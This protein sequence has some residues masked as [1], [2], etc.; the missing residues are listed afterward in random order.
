MIGTSIMQPASFKE[1][2]LM[3]KYLKKIR[4]G[5][6]VLIISYFFPSQIFGQYN[7]PVRYRGEFSFIVINDS[8]NIEQLEI[9]IPGILE[10]ENQKD[11]I[12]HRVTPD[13]VSN[14]IDKERK[15]GILYWK[16]GGLPLK[17]N[18]L[19]VRVEFS[20]TSYEVNYKIDPGRVVE[21]DIKSE[22]YRQFTKAEPYIESDR[23]KIREL[24]EEIVRNEKNHYRKARKI[25]DW[26]IDN[27]D[28]RLLPGLEGAAYALEKKHGECGEYSALFTALCRAAGIPARPVIG[29]MANP[30]NEPH[31][32]AEFYLENIGWIPVDATYADG[33]KNKDSWFGRLDNGR[34][35]LSKGFNV[36]LIPEIEI[37]SLPIFQIGAWWYKGD[38]AGARNTVSLNMKAESVIS[39]NKVKEY[40]NDKYG[41]EL[42]LPEEWEITNIGNIGSYNVYVEMWNRTRESR[43]CLYGREWREGEIKISPEEITEKDLNFFSKNLQGFKLFDKGIEKFRYIEGYGF[44]S[45]M[46]SY[47][48]GEYFSKYVYFT[49]DKLIYWLVFHSTEKNYPVD[50]KHFIK[51]ADNLH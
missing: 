23:P 12:I 1:E 21:Y 14:E 9:W 19:R 40:K 35:I 13:F 49:N 36:I 15:C 39:G 20:F 47:G 30:F 2:I 44:L 10:W 42:N 24:A 3:Q 7:N 11:V 27:L 18:S 22:I 16:F 37:K 31:V 4:F 25:Y 46:S 26:I 45:K 17:G 32:W 29:M 34:V 51:L 48:I 41:I 8:C 43:I 50:N 28:Y 33:W 6:T 38:N 5:L